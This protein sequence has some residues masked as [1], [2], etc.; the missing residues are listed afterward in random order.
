[1]LVKKYNYEKISRNSVDG[2]RLYSLPDGSRV[3]SVTT[4]LDKTK[5][6]EKQEALNRW[7]KSVGE[8]KAREITTEAANRGTRMHKWLED[9][10]ENNRDMGSPGTNPYSQQSFK[11]AEQIVEHGLK[12][13]DEMW[14]IEVPLYVPGLYAGTTMLVVFIKANPA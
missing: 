12:H 7:R 11:M 8:A 9:Y 2:Q 14:G 5:P 10:V 3:P 4:I 13:V 6:K 1:M